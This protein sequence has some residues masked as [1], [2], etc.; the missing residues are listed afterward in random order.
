M[1]QLAR[2]GNLEGV[3]HMKL[4]GVQPQEP[5]QVACGESWMSRHQ[6]ATSRGLE[7]CT[8]RLQVATIKVQLEGAQ[9]WRTVKNKAV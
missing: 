1:F 9:G 4:Q 5:L 8:R 2:R 3:L 7:P 6:G